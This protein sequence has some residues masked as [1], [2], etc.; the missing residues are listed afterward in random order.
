MFPCS[1]GNFIRAYQV[2]IL[3]TLGSTFFHALWLLA[4][5]THLWYAQWEQT[6][7]SNLECNLYL[8]PMSPVP[9][10]EHTSWH[11]GT[12]SHRFPG[13]YFWVGFSDSTV[14]PCPWARDNCTI[15]ETHSK[16]NS[17]KPMWWGTFMPGGVLMFWDWR[18]W[19]EIKIAFQIRFR[20]LLPLCIP[21]VGKCCKQ[22][23][24]VEKC[25]A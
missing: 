2:T 19:Q 24:C 21:K 16:V 18:H 14:I 12:P 1:K 6:S 4:T 5:F 13:I 3:K 23:E 20:S 10:H 7:K 25:A 17:W 22:S 15:W 11:K 8:L 9:K